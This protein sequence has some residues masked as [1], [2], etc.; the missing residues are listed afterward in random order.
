MSRIRLAFFGLIFSTSLHAEAVS[1]SDMDNK[2]AAADD[3]AQQCVLL[4]QN[5][6]TGVDRAQG[7]VVAKRWKESQELYSTSADA[8]PRFVQ[9]CPAFTDQAHVL[10]T[11]VKAELLQVKEAINRQHTCDEAIDH[12][13]DLDLQTSAA[14]RENKDPRFLDKL[15]VSAENS[16]QTAVENCTGSYHESAVSSLRAAQQAR[17]ENAELLAD[18]PACENAYKNAVAIGDLARQAKKDRRHEES[19][20]LYNKLHMAWNRVA[21]NCSGPRNQMAKK[22]IESSSLEASNAQYCAPQWADAAE[23][24]KLLNQAKMSSA[25]YAE[26]EL[27]MNK[28]EVLWREAVDLCKGE[29]QKQAKLN[30]D[31]IAKERAT[32]LPITAITELGKH[33]PLPPAPAV[34]VTEITAPTAAPTLPVPDNKASLSAPAKVSAK[35]VEMPAPQTVSIPEKVNA[36]VVTDNTP[37]TVVDNVKF[38]GDFHSDGGKVTGSGV[39]EFPDGDIYRGRIIQGMRSGKGR[40]EWKNGQIYDGDWVDDHATGVGAILFRNGNRYQG[41]VVDGAPQGQGQ[42]DLS[43]GDRYVGH[44][45]RGVFNGQGTYTWK[46]G[47]FY[48]GAWKD[49]KKNGFGKTIL[50]NGFGFEGEYLDDTETANVK[51]IKP[52][53]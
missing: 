38:Q 3:Q 50:P 23:A 9:Q 51:R 28:A 48:T 39:I 22:E 40:L 2:T 30:A 11:Q 21:D 53:S 31:S 1:V 42:L 8:L 20:M 52:K 44:F 18:S 10:E 35:I 17:K 4:L 6:H 7:M 29:P 45:D 13:F 25:V 49:G 32:P 24:T 26:R 27:L 43:S 46:S 16:W 33:R 19:I 5:I 36:P 41:D 47:S 34:Q 37:L 14:R 12:G 15:L